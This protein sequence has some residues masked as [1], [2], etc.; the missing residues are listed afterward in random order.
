MSKQA[1]VV[2][3]WNGLTNKQK[4]FIKNLHEKPETPMWKFMMPSSNLDK[5]YDDKHMYNT[6]PG[7][8]EG[9]S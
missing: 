5:A 6:L 1:E 9:K 7:W 3:W 4:E 8:S 2:K